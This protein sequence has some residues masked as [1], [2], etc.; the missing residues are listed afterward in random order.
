VQV[1]GVGD[2][3]MGEE[4]CAWVKVKEDGKTSAEELVQFSIGEIAH[5]KI[6]RYFIFV[7]EFP[8]TVTGKVKKNDMRKIT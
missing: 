1:I 5:F 6:P 7:K 2:E 3:H 8:L 4:I